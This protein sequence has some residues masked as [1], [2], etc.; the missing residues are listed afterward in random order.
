M[1]QRAEFSTFELPDITDGE[2]A[3]FQD[4]V[5]RYC[6][7][8]LHEGKKALVRNRLARR[9]RYYELNGFS[10]Y[11]SIVKKNTDE[12]RLFIDLI[13][14]NETHFFREPAHFKTYSQT[15]L[16]EFEGQDLKVWCA[17]SSSGEEPYSIAMVTADRA[18]NPRWNITGT[19]I[20]SRVLEA[21]RRAVYPLSRIT[22]IPVYYRSRFLMKGKGEM[23]GFFRIAPELRE[24]VTYQRINLV[25]PGDFPGNFH[26]IF[27]RNVLIYFDTQTKAAVIDQAVKRLRSGGYLFIGH[28][29]TCVH[30][31]LVR[32]CPAVYKRHD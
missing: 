10:E 19:D 1:I 29:E 27:L 12:Q 25:D 16:K 31:D 7:I 11:I 3:Q 9:L 2:F 32:V 14:T 21:A 20:S 6:G 22:E 18:V 4:M 15:M 30:S 28:S 17:A 23:D 24:H 13:T 26:G 8:F 5:Y